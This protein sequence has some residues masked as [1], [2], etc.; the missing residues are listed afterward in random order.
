VVENFRFLIPAFL[1]ALSSS[2]VF[3]FSAIYPKQVLA[4]LDP[5]QLATLGALLVVF[6]VP[7]GYLIGVVSI[8]A[9]RAIAM[10]GPSRT[11]ETCLNSAALQQIL[12]VVGSSKGS[13]EITEKDRRKEELYAVATYDHSVLPPTIHAWIQKRWNAFMVAAH[14]AT[15]V[16]LSALFCLHPSVKFVS[17]WLVFWI[18]SVLALAFSAWLAWRNVMRMIEFQVARTA[19]VAWPPEKPLL[20]ASPQNIATASSVEKKDDDG[21]LVILPNPP[22]LPKGY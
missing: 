18:P 4:G 2:I 13:K 20:P 19:M 6:T 15:A 8:L 5:A 16:V 7:A 12:F 22:A 10:F 14:S 17:P 1:F 11:Y 21:L 9:L 3:W